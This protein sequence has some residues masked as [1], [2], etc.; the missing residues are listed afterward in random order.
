MDSI[1][2][3]FFCLISESMEGRMMISL[4]PPPPSSVREVRGKNSSFTMWSKSG[5]VRGL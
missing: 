3:E 2:L 4:I 5:E 1:H